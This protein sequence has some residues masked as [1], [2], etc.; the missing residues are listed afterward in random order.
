MP[1]NP[2]HR[3]AGINKGKRT[4]LKACDETWSTRA[5]TTTPNGCCNFN[6]VMHQMMSCPREVGD[7]TI[8]QFGADFRYAVEFSKYGR[9]PL[10][11]SRP[12]PGQPDL[13]Y[14]LAST[15]PNRRCQPFRLPWRSASLAASGSRRCSSGV[16]QGRPVASDPVTHPVTVRFP[17]GH[18]RSYGPVAAY[19][20]PAG[21]P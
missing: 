10:E 19:V 20:K 4:P 6:L 9:A 11:V 15:T 18:G 1:Y 8:N 16:S 7:R 12:P 14:R 5:S 13:H 17:L 2:Q 3:S 21:H